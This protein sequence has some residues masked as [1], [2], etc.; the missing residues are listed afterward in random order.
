MSR[1]RIVAVLVSLPLVVFAVM[2]LVSGSR[3]VPGA[4]LGGGPFTSG[5]L[6]TG[7]EPDWSFLADR[8]TIEMQLV[9]PPR[10]RVLWVA[11]H[12]GKPYVVSGFM[13][14]VLGSLWK[15]WPEQ[16]ERDP[17]AFLRIDGVQYERRLIRVTSGRAVMEGVS[18]ELNR[19][20][21][22]GGPDAIEAGDVWL[23][24]LAPS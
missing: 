22:F 8:E 13:G 12:E 21:G 24:E 15:H 17:R 1:K 16:A 5:E 10:S 7:P 14:S 11:V 3:D 18:A 19:K 9:D 2:L 20:Y 6:H 23:F 4:W